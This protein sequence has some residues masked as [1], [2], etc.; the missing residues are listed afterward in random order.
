[1]SDTPVETSV[2]Q[3]GSDDEQFDAALTQMLDEAEGMFV[4]P[5]PEPERVVDSDM[6]V[7]SDEPQAVETE[8]PSTGEGEGGPEPFSGPLPVADGEGPPSLN[9]NVLWEQEHG[10]P[11]TETEAVELLRIYDDI[12]RMPPQQ[13]QAVQEMFTEP[14]PAV[15]E[16]PAFP[17]A[18]TLPDYADP[19][20]AAAFQAQQEQIE[21]LRRHVETTSTAT[22][23]QQIAVEQARQEA[24]RR[25]LVAAADAART[26]FRDDHPDLTPEQYVR[27]ERRAAESPFYGA[28]VQQ[29][30][31]DLQ[32]AA[33]DLLGH[34]M[35]ELPDIRE[36]FDAARIAAAEKQ[37]RADAARK[38][39][40]SSVAGTGTATPSTQ[41][42]ASQGDMLEEIRKMMAAGDTDWMPE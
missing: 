9:L 26:Q 24:E 34:T 23:E 3:L 5:D 20:V 8:V 40:A 6:F 12:R 10:R 15:A 25:Q 4:D 19:E 22:R 28:Y 1:V 31:G 17:A 18:P 33:Y 38:A 42:P 36:S 32:K 11:P 16:P 2:P 27:I 39:K 35:N 14:A 21:A 29:N 37:A 7:P 30:G 41:P 13:A